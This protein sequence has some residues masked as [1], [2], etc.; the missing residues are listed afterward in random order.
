[1]K[2]PIITRVEDA[3]KAD[4]SKYKMTKEMYLI[5]LSWLNSFLDDDLYMAFF[6]EDSRAVICCLWTDSYTRE[7][8]DSEDW[9]CNLILNMIEDSRSPKGSGWKRGNRNLVYIL[10]F[11]IL[12]L[13]K[14]EA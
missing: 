6:G 1:M 2:L 12:E 10:T 7:E 9:T 5:G 8:W 3:R 14:E 13:K 11:P 4:P